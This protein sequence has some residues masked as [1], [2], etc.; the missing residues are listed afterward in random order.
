MIHLTLRQLEYFAAAV[1]HGGAAR[2]AQAL[3]VS[4]PSVSKAV[5]ELEAHWGERLFVRLH[6]RGLEP[7]A[8]GLADTVRRVTCWARRRWWP[9]RDAA[10][11]RACC[12]SA[13]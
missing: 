7:T 4:Q 10:R 9:A 8:A 6:A 13:A 1:E 12:A 11:C 3:G 5:A 2:A